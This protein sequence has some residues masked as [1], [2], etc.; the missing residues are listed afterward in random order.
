MEEKVEL[1]LKKFFTLIVI[2]TPVLMMYK[3]GSL[4]MITWMLLLWIV[5][6]ILFRL[7][8]RCE[9][10]CTVNTMLFVFFVYS[11]IASILQMIGKNNSDIDFNAFLNYHFCLLVVIFWA[12]DWFEYKFGYIWMKR[13]AVFSTIYIYIYKHFYIK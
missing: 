1:N 2:T 11:F 6:Y 10:T 8:V 5:G 7:G 4:P 13:I 9:S 12:T 3:L